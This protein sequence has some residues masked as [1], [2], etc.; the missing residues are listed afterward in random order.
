MKDNYQCISP[1]KSYTLL[2]LCSHTY[3]ADHYGP[4][5][6]INMHHADHLFA[7]C[8]HFCIWTVPLA[9]VYTRHGQTLTR[10]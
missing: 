8:K 2:Q 9:T 7:T 10:M 3:A 4:D 6:V 1:G 5:S